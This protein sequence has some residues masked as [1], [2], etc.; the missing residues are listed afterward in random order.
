M[1][2]RI[3]VADALAEAGVEILRSEGQVTVQTGLAPERLL[4][5]IPGYEALVVRSATRV[6]RDVLSAGRNLRVVARAGV[7]VDNIDVEEATRR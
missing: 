4:E 7:G 1:A 3:L 5:T 2:A 6:T